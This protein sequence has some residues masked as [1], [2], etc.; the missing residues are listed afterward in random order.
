MELARGE[1]L[2]ARLKRE[3]RLSPQTAADIFAQVLS[4]I[5]AA[6]D[7]G[8]V[9]RDLKPENI[10]LSPNAD[11]G[12]TARILDFGLAK[13]MQ[14][15]LSA[16]APTEVTTPGTVMGT[17]G[18]MSP[19]QLTGGDV[20]HRSDL[21]SIGAMVVE[22]VTG[23]LPFTGRTYHELLTNIIQMPFHLEDYSPHAERLDAVLQ[24]CLAKDRTARFASAAEMQRELI[25]ALR[26][27]ASLRPA[28]GEVKSEADTFIMHKAIST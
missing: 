12:V 18:Y 5:A 24:K 13:A 23:R 7:A 22:C 8:I 25:V 28:N 27:C 20:D 26:A 1:M 6:H 11:N 16:N 9:H 4:G 15:D 14:P 3:K 2:G 19:E 10:L 21:F 17:F